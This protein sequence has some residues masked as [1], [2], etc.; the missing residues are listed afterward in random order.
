MTESTY[1]LIILILGALVS[2][3]L[4]LDHKKAIALKDMVPSSFAEI[5]I[6]LAR[7]LAKRTPNTDDDEIVE[8]LA[9]VL[10]DKGVVVAQ[11]T[12]LDGRA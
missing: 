9:D 8:K 11:K 6:N 5:G 12:G 7:D 3:V 10:I 4:Y 2:G 1:N